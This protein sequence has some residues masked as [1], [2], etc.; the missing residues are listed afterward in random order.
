[1]HFWTQL[2][3]L[4]ISLFLQSV[5]LL[6]LLGG[7]GGI[8][9][10]ASKLKVVSVSGIIVEPKRGSGSKSESVVRPGSG[11]G[12]VDSF[13]EGVLSVVQSVVSK[14]SVV[15]SSVAGVSVVFNGKR[16][17]GEVALEEVSVKSGKLVTGFKVVSVENSV[18]VVNSLDEVV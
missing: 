8:I 18:K 11:V 13:E 14:R 12:S 15:H 3:F 4:Q 9:V 2:P 16:S 7:V 17:V 6:Q 5:E 1:M 10:V